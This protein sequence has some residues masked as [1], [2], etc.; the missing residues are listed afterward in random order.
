MKEMEDRDVAAHEIKVA[1]GD[2]QNARTGEKIEGFIGLYRDDNNGIVG[3]HS[4][5]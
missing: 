2:I 5:K 1:K 3:I 4:D